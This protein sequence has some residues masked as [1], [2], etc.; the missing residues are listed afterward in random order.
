VRVD[1]PLVDP[2]ALR[3]A[4]VVDVHLAG[5]QDVRLLLAVDL[6]PVDVELVVHA[7]VEGQALQLLEGVREPGRV[8]QPGGVQLGGLRPQLVGRDVLRRGVVHDLGVV[9]AVRRTGRLDVAADVRLLAAVLVGF[10]GTAGCRPGR[11]RRS[12][13]PDTTSSPSAPAGS[14]M[15]RTDDVGEEQQR[16]DDRDADEDVLGGSTALTSV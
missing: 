14:R 9:D 11:C 16:A 5:R 6:V 2:A 7:E 3:A 15:L 12:R 1:Q 4:Q 10:T 13:P 8:E